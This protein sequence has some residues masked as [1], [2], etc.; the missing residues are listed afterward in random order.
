MNNVGGVPPIVV[1]LVVVAFL[2]SAALVSWYVIATTSSAV[3]KPLVYAEPGAYIVGSNLY[4]TLRNDGTEDFNGLITV[5]L[6]NGAIGSQSVAIA[7]GEAV[8]VVIEL[9]GGTFT[10]GESIPGIIRTP[11]GEQKI[12]VEVLG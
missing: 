7:K 1:V 11:G 3:R 2:V 9:S 6:S 8:N 12:T 4:V 5:V 10:A